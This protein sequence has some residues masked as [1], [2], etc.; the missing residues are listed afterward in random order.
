MN[1]ENIEKL[2]QKVL[3]YSGN[4]RINNYLDLLFICGSHYSSNKEELE[5]LID[6]VLKR[7]LN[8]IKDNAAIDDILNIK[9][10]SKYKNEKAYEITILLLNKYL[11]NN[12]TLKGKNNILKTINKTIIKYDILDD[13]ILHYILNYLFKI[14]YTII[15]KKINKFK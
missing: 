14:H 7:I 11:E 6:Q 5:Y 13:T 3:K 12:L 15:N 8:N 2:Y 10:K 9:I 4:N 1:N